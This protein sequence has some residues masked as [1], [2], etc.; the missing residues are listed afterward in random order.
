M[1]I[2]EPFPTP[3][4]IKRQFPATSQMQEF[5]K[6]SRQQI[7]NILTGKDPRWLAIIGP[8]SLHDNIAALEYA[9]KLRE[10]A[11]KTSDSLFIVM[12]TYYEKSRTA[13]GWKG[14]FYDPDMNGSQ[15]I[16][17]GT[18][19]TREILLNLAEIQVPAAAEILDPLAF[20][21]FSD[22]LSW[23]CIG[24]RTATSQIHRQIASGFEIP[25]GFKNSLDGNLDSAIN[26]AVAAKQIHRY[27]GINEEG[28]I[29]IVTTLGNV[30]THIVLR[31]SESSGNYD[32]PSLVA[33]Q[34]KLINAGITNRFLVDCSHGNSQRQPEQQETVLKSL[35]ASREDGFETIGGIII[36]SHLEE[37]QQSMQPHLT[38][39]KSITDPCLGWKETEELILALHERLMQQDCLAIKP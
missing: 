33:C 5:V 20:P 22:L 16:L 10:L 25:V 13:A 31:G 36:E 38:Y 6:S 2:T 3:I 32:Q 24:A 37:G 23:S 35:L 28:K 15:D 8:C 14:L 1:A 21:Y 19:K 11:Q 30:D 9:T 34:Q 29:S 7:H 26:G 12:R 4:A 39:G 18:H 17:R 27:L